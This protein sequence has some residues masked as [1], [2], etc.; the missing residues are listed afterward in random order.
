[1][2]LR[3]AVLDH[4]LATRRE[5]RVDARTC[6]CCQTDAAVAADGPVVVYRDRSEEEIRDIKLLRYARGRWSDPVSVHEDGWRIAGCP[7]NGPA[8]AA[9]GNDVYVAWFTGA[10]GA[11][12]A[13]L[14]RSRDG[15]L[16]F[17]RP[18]DLA[19]QDVLGRVD[20]ALGREG[21]VWATWLGEDAAA[22]HVRIARFDAALAQR[23]EAVLAQLPRGRSTGFPRMA[24]AGDA[25]HVVWT[26]FAGGEPSIAGAR[27]R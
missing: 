3:A 6:D 2:A 8:V 27:V 13:L 20:V 22:Q 23:S 18:I 11:P 25:V 26:Q 16:S 19:T 5:W 10:N 7:V 24:A 17:A 15:G 4:A 1:M 21:A 14:A 9:R 12:R